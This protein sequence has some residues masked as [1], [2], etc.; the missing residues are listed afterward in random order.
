VCVCVPVRGM[1]ATCINEKPDNLYV[2]FRFVPSTQS[3]ELRIV[4]VTEVHNC[5]S[6]SIPPH[7]HFTDVALHYICWQREMLQEN[8]LCLNP[9]RLSLTVRSQRG[10]FR[11]SAQILCLSPFTGKVYQRSYFVWGTEQSTPTA[12]ENESVLSGCN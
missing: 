2:P 9:K 4:I 8:I 12:K 11:I 6:Y 3:I 1:R 7:A 10:Q 5:N